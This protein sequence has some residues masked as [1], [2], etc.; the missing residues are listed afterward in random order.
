MI[1]NLTENRFFQQIQ[2]I[3]LINWD[4]DWLEI[5]YAAQRKPF[6]KMYRQGNILS[7]IFFHIWVWTSSSFWFGRR[8]HGVYSF[9][10]KY[11]E[12]RH[13]SKKCFSLGRGVGLKLWKDCFLHVETN[14]QIIP[15]G[16]EFY[17]MHFPVISNL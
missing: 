15:R 17:K 1:V 14:G 16:K 9:S 8:F 3:E 6:R 10:L 5:H 11:S 7:R 4:W 2:K 13:F 12:G